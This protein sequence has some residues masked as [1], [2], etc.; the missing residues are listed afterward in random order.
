MQSLSPRNTNYCNGIAFLHGKITVTSN[1]GLI[2]V[3]KKMHQP[4]NGTNA[5]VVCG[6]LRH[7]KGDRCTDINASTSS[8]CV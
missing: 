7:I 8:V 3:Q 2:S 4:I 5:M 6:M 1:I